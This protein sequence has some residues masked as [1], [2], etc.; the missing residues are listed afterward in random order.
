MRKLYPVIFT[1]LVFQF[2]FLSAQPPVITY[3]PV[4]TGLTQP[5]DLV[6]AGDGTN[7][8]FIAQQNGLIRMWNGSVLS[9]FLNVGSSRENLISVGGEQGLLSMAFHPSYDG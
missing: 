7:R 1:A 5:I 6:N 4:I 2:Q 9:D 8:L 3:S